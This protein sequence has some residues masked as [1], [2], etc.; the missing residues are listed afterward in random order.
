MH[1]VGI[2]NELPLGPI[3]HVLDRG[4]YSSM[5]LKMKRL[6]TFLTKIEKYLV[7]RKSPPGACEWSPPSDDR[8]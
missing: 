6:E 4:Q 8:A 7:T 3:R 1:V 2:V 5:T